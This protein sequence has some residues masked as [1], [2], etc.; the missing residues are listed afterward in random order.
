[1]QTVQ[2]PWQQLISL[3]GPTMLT[4]TSTSV[5][6]SI[7]G[8]CS[9]QQQQ[10]SNLFVMNKAETTERDKDNDNMSKMLPQTLIL[11]PSTTATGLGAST[12][13][14][15]LLPKIQNSSSF[16]MSNG[17]VSSCSKATATAPLMVQTLQTVVGSMP[18]KQILLS[19]NQP[20]YTHCVQSQQQSTIYY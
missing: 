7:A 4:P 14:P 12:K 9:L 2:I 17:T 20:V 19:T 8:T 11:K 5:T 1:M 6:S 3:G 10:S 13:Q 15:V 16:F 18:S